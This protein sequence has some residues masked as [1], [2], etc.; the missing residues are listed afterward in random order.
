MPKTHDMI[1]NL[2]EFDINLILKLLG[3]FE[4]NPYQGV[5]AGSKSEAM[6]TS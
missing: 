6:Q 1:L 3:N 2:N 5:P 4:I